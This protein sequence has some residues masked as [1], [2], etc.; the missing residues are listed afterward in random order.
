MIE[1]ALAPPPFEFTDQMLGA[2]LRQAAD[3]R[4]VTSEASIIALGLL[5]GHDSQP[6]N[7]GE[8]HEKYVT[9]CGLVS[10]QWHITNLN[11]LLR[12]IPGDVV[13]F[14]TDT[15]S[16]TD[17]TYV[18]LSS[19]GERIAGLGGQL[20][21]LSMETGVPVRKFNPTP[22]Q[23]DSIAKAFPARNRLLTYN[24]FLSSEQPVRSRDLQRADTEGG[25]SL[26]I[27]N[28]TLGQLGESGLAFKKGRVNYHDWNEWLATDVGRVVFDKFVDISRRFDEH[29]AEATSSGLAILRGLFTNE[30]IRKR[31][32]DLH[33]R[34]QVA[35]G[36]VP[37][38][39]AHYIDA[40]LHAAVLHKP[41]TAGQPLLTA[42]VAALLPAEKISSIKLMRAIGKIGSDDCHIERCNPGEQPARWIIR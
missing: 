29:D 4:N 19:T 40:K 38:G 2:S 25:I 8:V 22:T 9:Y 32:P 7:I 15:I 27:A 31:L 36:H 34:A 1:P 5:P 23:K 41:D 11:R 26:A 24:A 21:D 35:N 18:R 14:S 17:K 37:H 10:I 3:L 28:N 13:E 30:D 42:E 12:R 33:R 16:R 6:V 39:A 20:L